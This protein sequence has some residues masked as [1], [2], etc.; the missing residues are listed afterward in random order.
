[1]SFVAAMNHPEF[2]EPDE[3]VGVKGSDVYTETGVGD[4]RVSFYTQL[5]RDCAEEVCID[6]VRHF[7]KSDHAVLTDFLVILFQTRDIRGGKG[8][9]MLFIRMFTEVI[10]LRPQW[11]SSLCKLIPEY[12]CWKDIWRI[13]ERLLAYERTN[14]YPEKSIVPC[15]RALDA[16][17]QE[18]WAADCKADH[19]SLLAKWLPREGSKFST[20]AK[21]YADCL[22]PDVP[23]ENYARMRAYRKAVADMNR[24]IDTTEIKMCGGTW[25]A[26][27]P[28]KV[29]G[30][31][32]K[33]CKNAFWNKGGSSN[34][35]R[36]KCAENFTGYMTNVKSG[37]ETMKGS[38]VIYP[39]ELVKEVAYER[40]NQEE[41]QVIQAQ[42]DA[43]R[44]ATRSAGGL[45]NA[46][47]MCDF[48]GS[49]E[50][51]P[52]LVSFAL[53]ILGSE[54]VSEPFKD[55][56]LTFDSTPK[57]HSF[58]GMTELRKKVRSVEHMGQGLSTN[59][60]G[61]CDLILRRLVEHKVPPSEAPT[62][63]IVLTDM[64]FDKAANDMNTHNKKN[65]LWQ[66]HFQMIRKS[67]ETNGYT[68]PR[69]VC[70]NLRAEYKDYQAKAYEVGVV[71]LSGWSP[72][73]FKAI[74]QNGV[75]VCT[76]YE[77]LR[78]VLDDKRYDP[79]REV[80]SGLFAV[81]ST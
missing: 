61:A 81:E 49:M 54:L 5:N 43:I 53:G 26:I 71:Q 66:T 14:T 17:I 36:V 22:F 30:R 8:E 58:K 18:Q 75:Q 79:V 13:T 38:N 6:H 62:D 42:W 67:F 70:W 77:G 52:K 56:I 29:P 34:E 55:H 31:L 74:S 44:E 37:K 60:Q 45:S 1:M 68:P 39:H 59:F 27:E 73:A 50:G 40:C 69:I 48:S 19:P 24:R 76:P 10:R 9:K 46:V 57:W 4:L 20:L 33:R 16:F 25:A 78:K 35:D 63:L 51:V 72:S 11:V 21:H 23:E 41:L 12:G 15:I 64:G 28:R 32:M 3:G 47:F 7:L 65:Q 2:Y 80:C